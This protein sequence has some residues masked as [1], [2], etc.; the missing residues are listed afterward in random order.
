M[1]IGRSF[2]SPVGDIVP[3]GGTHISYIIG[4]PEQ[5]GMT[6]PEIDAVYEKHGESIGVEANARDEILIKAFK[7]GWMRINYLPNNDRFII[8]CW[9][10]DPETR[11]ALRKFAVDTMGGKYGKGMSYSDVVV[12][13]FSDPGN[14]R[15]TSLSGLASGKVA[16]KIVPMQKLALGS[17]TPII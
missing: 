2:I 17:R 10:L 15:V 9:D 6:R 1:A 13:C 11:V 3:T 5:F 16:F 4:H 14:I 12:Q 7:A 8:N